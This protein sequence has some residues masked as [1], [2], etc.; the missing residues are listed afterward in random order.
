M[1]P[2]RMWERI[3]NEV[4][5]DFSSDEEA[6]YADELQSRLED[7]SLRGHEAIKVVLS[8]VVRLPPQLVHLAHLRERHQDTVKMTSASTFYYSFLQKFC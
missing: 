5:L 7:V 4:Y 1:K 8:M 6:S 3:W 2:Q